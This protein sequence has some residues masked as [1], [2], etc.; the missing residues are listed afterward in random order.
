MMVHGDI[1]AVCNVNIA[2][3]AIAERVRKEK[4]NLRPAAEPTHTRLC[5]QK[6]LSAHGNSFLV[7]PQAPI[8]GWMYACN[9]EFP[10]SFIDG[11]WIWGV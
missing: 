10:H 9:I 3:L 8:D 7:G 6:T 4:M 2:L 5:R 1:M 11:T